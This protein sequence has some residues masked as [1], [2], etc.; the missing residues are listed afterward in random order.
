MSAPTLYSYRYPHPAV[1]V[2]CVLFGCGAD[3]LKVLLIQRKGDPFK[4]R[5]AFP[6]GFVEIDE[7]LEPAAQRELKEETGV[8]GVAVRQFQTFG[9]PDRDSRERIISVAF[10][11]LLR[12]DRVAAKASSDARAVAWF[13]LHKPPPLAFDHKFILKAA[14]KRMRETVRLEPVGMDLLPA[15]FTFT[16]AHSL[17]ELLL[18][19]AVDRRRLR[20]R[21][22]DFGLLA[23]AGNGAHR[24]EPQFK[25]DRQRYRQLQRDGFV[26]EI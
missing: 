4:G 12:M 25:F 11:G 17:Y 14:L 2:D 16:A 20:S 8:A 7:D 22:L 9:A 18:G 6:G 10:F 13:D 5:W 26:L 21:L 1:T 19:R 24:S 3:T 15:R 23:P